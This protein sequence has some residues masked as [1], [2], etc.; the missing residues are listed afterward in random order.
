M[1]KVLLARVGFMKLYKGPIQ[2]D[3]RPMAGGAHNDTEIGHEAYNFLNVNGTVYGYFQPPYIGGY[4]I[5]LRRIDPNYNDDDNAT[6]GV[7]VIWFATDPMDGGQVVIGWYKNA[8]VFSSIQN[9]GQ[10]NV[11]EHPQRNNYDYNVISKYDDCVLL[12]VNKRKFI[13]GGSS[14]IIGNPGQ[15]NVFYLRD[16]NGNKIKSREWIREIITYTKNYQST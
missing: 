2:G 16:A 14:G 3:E 7:L 10:D 12:P 9:P 15:A 6:T 11:E 4:K 5:N 13:V 8:K 1:I